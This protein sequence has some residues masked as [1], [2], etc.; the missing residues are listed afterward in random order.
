MST[1]AP[2]KPSTGEPII[3][4][5]ILSS[6][7]VQMTPVTPAEAMV[8]PMS[9]PK[10]ACDE[11]E[12]MPKYQ[13]MKFQTTAPMSAANTTGRVTRLVSTMPSPTVL[14]TPVVDEGAEEVQARGHE[15]R[16]AR[17]DGARRHRGRDRVGGVVEAVGVV[18][19]E[20]QNDDRDEKGHGLCSGQLCL[21]TML[22]M[23]LATCSHSSMAASR[24]S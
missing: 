12:G 10:S 13:V 24:I 23:T 22:S 4:M 17:G 21:R 5:M 6:T 15:H 7:P 2:R 9:P 16:H 1:Q 20:R 3:G 14:A 11:L 18:E 19:D 8:A